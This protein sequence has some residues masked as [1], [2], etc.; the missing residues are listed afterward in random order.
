[1][2]EG[3]SQQEEFQGSIAVFAALDEWYGQGLG[4]SG[5]VVLWSLDSK[6]PPFHEWAT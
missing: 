4:V 6:A 3:L 5:H 2:L 1:M